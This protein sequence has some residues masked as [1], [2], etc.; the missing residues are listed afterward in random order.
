MGYFNEFPHTRGYDGDLGWLIKMYKELVALYK[1]N[2]DY[3]DDIIKNLSQVVTQLIADGDIYLS[4]NYIEDT[5]TLQFI[6]KS[7]V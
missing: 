1:S 4:T 2:N 6:F 5:K 3:L 7:E